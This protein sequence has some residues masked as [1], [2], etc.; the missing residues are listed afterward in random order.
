MLPDESHPIV[1]RLPPLDTLKEIYTDVI[2]KSKQ[3]H[4][5]FVFRHSDWSTSANHPDKHF[6]DALQLASDLCLS[7]QAD[8]DS[9]SIICGRNVQGCYTSSFAHDMTTEAHLAAPSLVPARRTSSQL[10]ETINAGGFALDFAL[11]IKSRIIHTIMQGLRSVV[12]SIGANCGLP[13]PE[14]IFF[15]DAGFDGTYGPLGVCLRIS[16][17]RLLIMGKMGMVSQWLIR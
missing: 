16:R 7:G 11:R 15:V 6:A 9:M 8:V 12:V 13:Q 14:Q 10:H 3:V 5:I 1:S 2:S 17:M 4:L